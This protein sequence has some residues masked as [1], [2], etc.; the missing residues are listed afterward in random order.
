VGE[1]EPSRARKKEIE[2]VQIL[3]GLGEK[4]KEIRKRDGSLGARRKCRGI[5]T[6]WGNSAAERG[7]RPKVTTVELIGMDMNGG[8]ANTKISDL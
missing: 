5:G 8:Y 7:A 1:E 2:R 4:H 3:D 6:M